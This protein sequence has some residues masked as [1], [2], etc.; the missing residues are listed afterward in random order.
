MP[1]FSFEGNFNGFED[2]RFGAPIYENGMTSEIQ[3]IT[4]GKLLKRWS[5]LSSST[6]VCEECSGAAANVSLSLQASEIV[7]ASHKDNRQLACK[8]GSVWLRPKPERGSHSSGTTFARCLSQPTRMTGLET[9]RTACAV[10][11]IPIRSCS[12]WGLP[13]HRRCRRCGG[14]LPHPFTLTCRGRRFAFCGTFPEVALAGRY[15]APCFRGARTFLTLP[16]FDIGKARLPGQLAW[17]P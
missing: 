17:L 16:S 3:C 14:L 2:S 12:R 11:V 4:C 13:C 6:T 1:S 9:S 15:P 8:P 7:R 10:H 5:A